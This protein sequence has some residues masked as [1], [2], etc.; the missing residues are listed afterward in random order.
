MAI[1]LHRGADG[2]AKEAG[3][4]ERWP[5]QVGALIGARGP[6]LPPTEHPAMVRRP[7]STQIGGRKRR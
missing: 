5:N 4:P 2:A 7:V 3:N 6:P 1:T